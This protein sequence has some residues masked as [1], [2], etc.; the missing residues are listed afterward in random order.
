MT[1]RKIRKEKYRE[2]LIANLNTYKNLLVISV[3]NVGSSQMQQVRMAIRGKGEIL[4]GKNTIIRKVLRDMGETNEKVLALLPYIQGN[5][6][7]VFSDEDLSE[8]RKTVTSFTVPA[9]AKS[10]QTAPVDV[11][12]PAGITPLD[13]GQTSFFQ[14]LNIST[15]ITR[16]A[17]EIMTQVHLIKA[18]DKVSSS[19]VALLNKMGQKPFSYGI[20]VK[21]VYEDGSVYDAAVLDLTPDDMIARF[22]LGVRHIA[23][24]GL[25]IGYPTAASIPHSMANAFKKM[26]AISLE[27]SW[28]FEE[29]KIFHE[30][31]ANP[32]A[33]KSAAPAGGG[34][35]GAAAAAAPAPEPE[36]EEE[37]ED[38]GF[39]LFD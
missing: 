21:T 3:D 14:A 19:A 25:Q 7:F 28:Q 11:F 20:V 17:I 16:G 29:S 35:G 8:I 34:G 37:E 4:M 12:I 26:I 39:S 38:M 23:A 6:G 32:D 31:L 9:A 33:F 24:I 5:I 22:M 13:P 30:M 18:G 10:N 2:R 36:E 27:T 1:D 15:K